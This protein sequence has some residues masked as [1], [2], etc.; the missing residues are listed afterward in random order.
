MPIMNM[1][2]TNR[3]ILLVAV[4]CDPGGGP[5]GTVTLDSQVIVAVPVVPNPEFPDVDVRVEGLDANAITHYI[6]AITAQADGHIQ[7]ILRNTTVN[8]APG[9]TGLFRV[10]VEKKE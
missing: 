2:R 4:A 6:E 10:V 1:V 7:V 8:A 3:S 5:P 9:A